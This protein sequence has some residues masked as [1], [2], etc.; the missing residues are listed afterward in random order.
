MNLK[1][2]NAQY[3]ALLF[4]L[5]NTNSNLFAAEFSR[6]EKEDDVAATDSSCRGKIFTSLFAAVETSEPTIVAAAIEDLK[7]RDEKH[8]RRNTLKRK[9]NKRDVENDGITAI[10]KTSP[11]PNIDSLT[12]SPRACQAELNH[13]KSARL[14]IC[15]QLFQAG[16]SPDSTVTYTGYT[17]VEHFVK[18][19]SD[20][21]EYAAE[22]VGLLL[23][24]GAEMP[25]E[26]ADHP[27]V[28]TAKSTYSKPHVTTVATSP[29]TPGRGHATSFRTS[30]A[31]TK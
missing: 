3:T 10:F 14:N 23:Y 30:L 26:L 28:T 22:M 15:N 27:I 18:I 21:P 6:K 29:R 7:P 25:R 13:E 20:H 19:Y 17:A 2:K 1:L 4:L 5:I 31:S 24:H 9:V 11:L 12:G 8:A 16:L